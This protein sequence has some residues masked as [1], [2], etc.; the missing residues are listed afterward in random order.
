MNETVIIAHRAL[1]R[2]SLAVLLTDD[3]TGM[4]ITG[5]NARAW[6]EGEKPPVKKGDGWFV[7]TDLSAGQHTVLAEGGMYQLQQVTCTSDSGQMQ[8]ITIRLRPSRNYRVPPGCL[9]IEGTAEPGAKVTVYIPDRQN[10]CKLLTD[11]V[12]GSLKLSIFHGRESLEGG[13]FRLITS[14]GKGENVFVISSEG[15]N[16][17]NIAAPLQEDHPKVGSMLVPA[18]VT[19]ADS[20]GS[21][22]AV[23]KS[24]PS[25]AKI[26]FESYGSTVLLREYE[27][28]GESTICPV[29]L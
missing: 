21:F 26:V 15:G 6:I 22:F 1:S 20:K 3:L 2:V 18:V 7:F 8:T 25:G 14:G 9:R 11:A 12:K 19:E 28:V 17:Y 16:V 5:S 29:L 10:A 27:L 4:A 13:S 24:A 23:L